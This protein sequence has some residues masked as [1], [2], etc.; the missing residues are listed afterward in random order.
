MTS[1]FHESQNSSTDTAP[2]TL[3]AIQARAIHTA[4]FQ[5][6]VRSKDSSDL[7]ALHIARMIAKTDTQEM[8]A[9]GGV[10]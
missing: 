7:T 10:R 3:A 1:R 9:A 6:C 2:S 5:E 4:K 8:V